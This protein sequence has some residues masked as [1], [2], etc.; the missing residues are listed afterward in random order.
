MRSSVVYG[1]SSIRMDSQSLNLPKDLTEDDYDQIEREQNEKAKREML[2]A[3]VTLDF[4]SSDEI[5]LKKLISMPYKV[6]DEDEDVMM[7]N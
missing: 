6:M 3:L 7:N 1:D 4:T 2:Q 5:S